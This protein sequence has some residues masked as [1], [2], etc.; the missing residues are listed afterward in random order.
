[1]NDTR[2]PEERAAHP[3]TDARV[4][5]GLPI[6]YGGPRKPAP[7]TV[8]LR[9]IRAIVNEPLDERIGHGPTRAAQFGR[10]D[11]LLRADPEPAHTQECEDHYFVVH[12][13]G[14]TERT[15]YRVVDASGAQF[16]P[17]S[18]PLMSFRRADIRRA[19]YDNVKH[20]ARIRKPCRVER[21]VV[22]VGPWLPV[23]GKDR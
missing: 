10:I 13:S 22:S 3:A 1:M 19:Y 5:S 14:H 21:R 18:D 4:P 9:K 2:T 17:H 12:A 20:G 8:L 6:G 11:A 16:P 7:D 23:D 15:E